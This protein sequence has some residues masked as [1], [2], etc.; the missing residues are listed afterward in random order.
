M[1]CQMS[2]SPEALKKALGATPQTG[3]QSN[4]AS[5]VLVKTR[6]AASGLVPAGNSQLRTLIPLWVPPMIEFLKS[7]NYF[8]ATRATARD[9]ENTPNRCT[10]GVYSLDFQGIRSISGKFWIDLQAQ[11][12]S[13]ATGR[14]SYAQV[15]IQSNVGD[16]P[17]TLIQE[18]LLESLKESGGT[19]KRPIA[20]RVAIH[21]QGVAP[22]V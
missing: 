22:P 5:V 7:Q 11:I 6:Q 17:A 12:G 3:A 1:K 16:V 15:L 4:T 13:K 10:Q 14:N 8:N 2:A 19:E 9:E 21:A 20:Y 18:G